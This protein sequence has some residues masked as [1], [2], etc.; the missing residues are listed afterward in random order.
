LVVV[1]SSCKSD[2]VGGGEPAD[3]RIIVAKG[4]VVQAGFAVQVLALKTQVLAEKVVRVV[5][6][7]GVA[8]NGVGGAPDDLPRPPLAVGAMGK[9]QVEGGSPFGGGL[10]AVLCVWWGHLDWIRLWSAPRHRVSAETK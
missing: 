3:V 8:P 9:A 4:V 1:E 6:A 5:F 10:P 2:G 7:Q